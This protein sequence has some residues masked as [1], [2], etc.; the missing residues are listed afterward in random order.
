M[1]EDSHTAPW[2]ATRR[3]PGAG[4]DQGHRQHGLL[5]CRSQ[6]AYYGHGASKDDLVRLACPHLTF[7]SSTSDDWCLVSEFGS[8]GRLHGA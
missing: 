3:D 7:H 8:G 1:T 2:K 6:M 4:S 5:S